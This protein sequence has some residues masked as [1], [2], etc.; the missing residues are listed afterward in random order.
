[1]KDGF[2]G[3]CDVG[4]YLWSEISH[5]YTGIRLARLKSG[6]VVVQL[7]A[8]RGSRV[9][10]DLS[11]KPEKLI[12]HVKMAISNY[13]RLYEGTGRSWVKMMSQKRWPSKHLWFGT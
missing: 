2:F 11:T 10:D 1:M 5:P 8:D 12:N 4:F 3:N 6:T 7:E 9:W 13:I